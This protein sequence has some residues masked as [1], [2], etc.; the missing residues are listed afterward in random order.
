MSLHPKKS[1][2]LILLTTSLGLLLGGGCGDETDLSSGVLAE[3]AGRDITQ[4]AVD[5]VMVGT[6]AIG[7]TAE[8]M[9]AY[10]PSDVNGCVAADVA[11][12][13]PP[14]SRAER[15]QRCERRRERRADAALR[16]LIQGRWY[17]LEAKRRGLAVPTTRGQARV[18]GASAGVETEDLLAVTRIRLLR[19]QLAPRPFSVPVRFSDRQLKREYVNH[20]TRY[21]VRES[22]YI[23]AV[24]AD[25]H[26]KARRV[27][28]LLAR[29][30]P[31]SVVRTLGDGGLHL[32]FTGLLSTT[33]TPSSVHD[34]AGR[35][36]PGGVAIA[37]TPEGWYVL[38]LVQI[39]PGY[40]QSFDE[41]T[42][43]VAQDLQIRREREALETFNATLR[44]RYADDTA[45]A[46]SY[47]IA[48][49]Q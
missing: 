1:I 24:V 42:P 25:T 3:V 37:R 4:A 44:S 41:A 18:A 21:A 48:A 7:R 14:M 20:R 13:T 36:S 33:A 35:L 2:C 31:E 28:A 32:P 34:Q 15:R 29:S 10:S 30:T 43:A 17:A 45:C 40:R 5:R 22:R 46:P 38:R 11:R 23:R 12:A 19:D 8:T 6:L 39:A 26:G 16:L 27:A 49:C 9:P 47:E